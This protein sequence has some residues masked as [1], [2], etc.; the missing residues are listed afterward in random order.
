MANRPGTKL[1]CKRLREKPI[2]ASKRHI[3]TYCAL[4]WKFKSDDRSSLFL[5][6]FA[7][8]LSAC[9]TFDSTKADKRDFAVDTYYPASN[10]MQLTE[11]HARQYWQRMQADSE[12]NPGNLAVTASSTNPNEIRL[13]QR[14]VH[15]Y[16]QKNG[17]RYGDK[18][19]YLAVEAASVM[20]G[21]HN[22][23]SLAEHDQRAG[24]WFPVAA[25]MESGN[26]PWCKH[27][28]D[29]AGALTNLPAWP[30]RCDRTGSYRALPT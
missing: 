1:F 21:G 9:G 19:R 15:V 25:S 5:F 4:N 11:R 12:P 23:A 6:V 28:H 27:W 22:P 3:T 14:R 20:P 13:A 26:M 29:G 10:E 18:A 8:L 24:F 17:A 16:W 30:D 7:M 2:L